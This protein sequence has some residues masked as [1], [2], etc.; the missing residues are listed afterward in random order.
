[1]Y[2][3]TQKPAVLTAYRI[4]ESC[5]ARTFNVSRELLLLGSLLALLMSKGAGAG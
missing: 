1:M 5:R 2:A 3:R 4:A